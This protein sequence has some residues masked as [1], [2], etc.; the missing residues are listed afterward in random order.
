M[1][2][3]P[4]GRVSFRLPPTGLPI[5]LFKYS[6]KS[7][8]ALVRPDTILFDLEKRRFSLVWR[9]SQRIQKTILDFTQCW[10]GPP[11]PGMLR[12]RAMGKS[13]IRNFGGVP[14]KDVEDA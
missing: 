2:L 12:A 14:A 8:D 7:Y 3:T 5:A 6:R 4:E 10:V 9:V 13:Y 11:T 1:N